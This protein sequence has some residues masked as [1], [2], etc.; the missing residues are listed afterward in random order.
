MHVVAEQSATWFAASHFGWL[1][2]IPLLPLGAY[3]IQIF[4]GRLLPRKGDWLPTGAMFVALCIASYFFYQVFFGH[5]SASF[6]VD[7]VKHPYDFGF[8]W[9]PG[10]GGTFGILLDNLAA[11]MLFVVTLVSFLVHLFSTGYMHGDR[12]YNIF[13]ANIALFT[14]AML[15]LVL[16]NNF[17]TFFIAWELMGLCS[18][19]LI[20]HYFDKPSAAA[21]CKK[22]F[23]TTRIGDVML[24]LGI[25]ILYFKARIPGGIHAEGTL[26]FYELYDR[27]AILTGNGAHWNLG[28]PWFLGQ[29]WLFWA[30][31][32][33]FGG[34]VGKSAQFPLHIWLP[35]AME[36]PTPV[37][38]MIHAATM[39]AA[40]VFLVGRAFVFLS[41]DALWW[42]AIIGS[43][44]AIF[45]ASIGIVA[46]DIKKVLAYSTISQLG[47]MIAG[48]GVGGYTFALF[49]MVTHAFFKA[50]LFL[51]SGSVIHAVHTQEMPEMGGLRKK[52]PITYAT[53]LVSTLAIAGVPLFAGFYSKDGILANALEHG[54]VHHGMA[55]LPFVFLICAAAMTAFYMFRLIH[56]TFHG[57]PRD[58]HKYD[59]AHESPAS[60]AIPLIVLGALAVIGGQ[61][62]ILNPGKIFSADTWFTSIVHPPFPAGWKAHEVDEH[63]AHAAHNGAMYGSLAV[64]G[65]G[66]LLSFCFYK[67]K[68]F[69]AEK[70]AA[71]LAPLHKLVKNKYYIDEIYDKTII[72]FTYALAKLQ[73]AF[74]KNVID[75][76]VNGVGAANRAV[77]SVSGWFDRT[78]VDGLVNLLAD[79]TQIFGA[80]ARLF[81]SGRVQQYAAFAVAGVVGLAF[82]FLLIG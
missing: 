2:A 30:G 45:A 68:V 47:F 53:M 15:T 20:G 80:I 82:W 76:L 26:N 7:S 67:W 61:I 58:H 31:I 25:A 16:S 62:W 28:E 5:P 32:L 40:G 78:F 70:T 8:R 44:T 75:A 52:M 55:Y 57:E 64:A 37:S 19:M 59:H 42:V 23:L 48:L 33:V 43:F 36:G 13:F 50:C 72:A 24:F 34:A 3:A 51:G 69:S 1:L 17:L 41:P 65:L 11:S 39:V 21:A 9:V 10:A 73:S 22:A 29:N 63:I 79:I 66:I 27:I 56:L 35:D 74:D 18:Y 4:F 60:M 12:R 49:H 81:Q 71:V 77:S 6:M 54:M 14:F 46:T 38:A